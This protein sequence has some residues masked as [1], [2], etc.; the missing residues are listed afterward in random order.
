MRD[1]PPAAAPA[2]SPTP[3]PPPSEAAELEVGTL[4]A[5]L[6]PLGPAG[7]TTREPPLPTT[8]APTGGAEP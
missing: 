1:P 2:A 3:A 5:T 4:E 6:P 8:P 7:G